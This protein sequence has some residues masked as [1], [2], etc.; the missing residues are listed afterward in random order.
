MQKIN[1]AVILMAGRGTRMLP[2][3]R[4]CPKELFPI[5]NVPALLYILKECYES[6]IKQV[7]LVISKEKKVVKKFLR[8]DKSLFELSEKNEGVYFLKHLVENMEISFVYQGKLKGTGGATYYAKYFT[9]KEP[10]L[11]LSG[12]DLFISKT[13]PASLDIIKTYKKTGSYVLG[14]KEVDSKIASRYGIIDIERN[15]NEDEMVVKGIVEK[16]KAG[17]NPSN[18]ALMSRYILFP[19]IYRNI[20]KLYTKKDEEIKLPDAIMLEKGK[21]DIVAKNIEAD[22]YDL[23]NSDDFARCICELTRNDRKK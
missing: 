9:K 18:Y 23:G 20:K 8:K 21:C 17:E 22:Y 16:P 10:F 5:G 2:A 6:G 12:D 13:M 19:E 11:L 15:I 7:C 14:C 4:V 3:T 1:K